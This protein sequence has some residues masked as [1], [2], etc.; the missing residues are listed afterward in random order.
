MPTK[1]A[2]NAI[3]QLRPDPDHEI[4]LLGGQFH[5]TNPEELAH[6]FYEFSRS[7]TSHLCV[8]FHGGL[9]GQQDGLTTAQTLMPIFRKAGSYPFF[10]I[11]NSDLLTTLKELLRP[12][13]DNLQFVKAANRGFSVVARKIVAALGG[14]SIPQKAK[15]RAPRRGSELK[16][17]SERAHAYDRVWARQEGVQLSVTRRELA[18]FAS[19]LVDFSAAVPLKQRLFVAGKLHGRHNPLARIIHRFNTGHDH[20]LYTTIIEELLIAAQ[21]DQAGK[22]V[23]GQMKKD[24]DDAFARSATAG[25]SAF[26]DHLLDAWS[27]NSELRL[28][29]IGHSAGAIYVQRFIEALDDRI[30]G[31]LRK[32]VEV[33]T[34]AAA[35]SFARMNDGIEVWRRRVKALRVFGLSDPVEGGYWQVPFIYDKSLLYL[36][37]SLCEGDPDADKPLV[38]MQRYWS[39]DPPYDEPMLRTIVDFLTPARSVWAPTSKN[40]NPGH[41]TQATEHGGFPVETETEGSMKYILERGFGTI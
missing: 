19:S 14:D 41:R 39:D 10:F 28:T 37:S 6:A 17:L 40:A 5:D 18:E 35:L 36:V 3:A 20:G 31:D 15:A 8:F 24:V 11:W 16:S 7:G 25:G 29:L 33:I 2:G 32:Q 13:Q 1:N 21:F 34:L 38:G 30:P 27:I 12:Q 23:W 4:D 26:L 9:V 22:T